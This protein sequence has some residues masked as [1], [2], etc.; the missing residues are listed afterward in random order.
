MEKNMET[1]ME[2]GV[3]W[4]RSVDFA[5]QRPTKL[6]ILWSYTPYVIIGYL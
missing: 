2:T 5:M 4:G 3:T 1:E 6:Q